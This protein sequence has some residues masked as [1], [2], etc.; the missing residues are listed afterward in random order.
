MNFVNR[1]NFESPIALAEMP[2]P[3]IQ[4]TQKNIHY[5]KLMLDN[6][7]GSNSEMSTFNLYFYNSLITSRQYKEIA[8]VFNEVMEEELHHMEIFGEISLQLGA[9]PRLWAW[10]N[11]RNIYWTPSYTQYTMRL[12]DIISNAIKNEKWAIDK[13]SKQISNIKDMS[14]VENLNRIIMDEKKHLDKFT[15]LYNK[16]VC[17]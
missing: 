10:K 3:P 11:N 9:D 6:L 4:V 2:Y 17:D 5:E 1:P 7:A 12:K 14:I 15:Q 16:Y 8:D 13:Y